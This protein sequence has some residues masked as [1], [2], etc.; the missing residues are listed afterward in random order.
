MLHDIFICKME[1]VNNNFSM[2]FIFNTLPAC[3]KFQLYGARE[4]IRFLGET[5]FTDI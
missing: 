2:H 4:N 1:I 5:T 3:V